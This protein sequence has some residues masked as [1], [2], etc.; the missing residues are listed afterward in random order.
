LDA[1]FSDRPRE[2]TYFELPAARTKGQGRA[3]A[4]GLAGQA[5]D[6]GEV[7]DYADQLRMTGRDGALRQ[8][9]ARARAHG[10]AEEEDPATSTRS[11]PSPTARTTRPQPQGLPAA[12]ERLPEDARGIPVFMVLFGE[13]KEADLKAMVQTTGGASSTRGKT[14]LYAVFKDIR[15]YQ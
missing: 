6:A 9:P 15:A 10:R 8:R 7:R 1:A 14:P 12:Y 11:S 4:R 3:G 2:M 13:A 5:G